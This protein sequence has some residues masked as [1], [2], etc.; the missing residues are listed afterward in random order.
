M[1]RTITVLVHLL[2]LLPGVVPLAKLLAFGEPVALELI[3]LA[4]IN[5]IGWG[6]CVSLILARRDLAVRVKSLAREFGIESRFRSFETVA[7][8]LLRDAERK[9]RAFLP[10]LLERRIGSRE[11]LSRT[12]ERIVAHAFRLLEAES[13][14]LSLFDR[15]SGSYHSSFVLGKPFRRSA[16]AMLSGAIESD[17]LNEDVS[18][19]VLIEPLAFGGAVLGSLRIGLRRGRLPS[20]SDREITQLVALQA[21]LALINAQ[22]TDELKRM[23]IA[24]EESVKVKTGFLANLSHEIRAPLGIMLNAVEL[25]LDGLCGPI[26]QDQLD[27]LKMVRQNG[28]HLLELINDVLDYAKVE[29][30]KIV[31]NPEDILVN[32]LLK[33]I[34]AV[35]HK[36]ADAKSHTLTFK[37]AEGALTVS[38]DRRHI[39]QMLINL[40]T[41][42]IKYTPD[43]GKI[44]VWAER[45]PGNKIRLSVKDSGVGIEASDRSKV[46][47]PFERIQHAY[48]INQV[49]T[50][51]GMSLTK[52]LAEVNGGAVDFSSIPGKGSHFWLVLNAV[53][54]NAAAA[55]KDQETEREVRGNGQLVVVGESDSG[56]RSMLVRYLSQVGFRVA[57][58]ATRLELLDVLR[59]E[60]V[61]VAV[62]D[63]KMVDHESGDLLGEIRNHAKSSRLPLVLLSSRA[64]VFDIEKYLKAGVDRC[65]TKPVSLKELGQIL[66][67][68]ID[69]ELVKSPTRRGSVART[70]DKTTPSG[71]AS[72]PV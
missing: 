54:Y 7:N 20:Q 64:F 21:G 38:C 34:C 50:G 48:S 18:P 31:P 70:K 19:D 57:A 66:R 8:A 25:V 29:S 40:L 61:A 17:I 33:D 5:L 37:P 2:I 39:R 12:L 44:E 43:K 59:T 62:L 65:L 69:A 68:L 27:T 6:L 13:A 49:G 72:R 56:E 60:E 67:G 10:N 26:S 9:N 16:Q 1:K 46:F 42:A 32:D 4:S 22:Y 51:L 11:E 36:Q 23:K 28:E 55:S 15:D 52:R 58:P 30:G 24:S 53:E 45:I 35:V 41:N 14:E 63:N 47:S 71:S 3:V